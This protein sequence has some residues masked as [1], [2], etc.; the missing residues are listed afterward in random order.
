MNTSIIW[1]LMSFNFYLSNTLSSIFNAGILYLSEDFYIV[2]KK[3]GCLD[4]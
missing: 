2:S 1:L 3:L 4:I